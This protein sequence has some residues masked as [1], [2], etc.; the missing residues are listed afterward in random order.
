MTF[1]AFF[2]L[3]MYAVLTMKAFIVPTGSMGTT[4]LGYHKQITCP[5]CRASFQ[6]NASA[7]ADGFQ[8]VSGCTC[9]N[10]RFKIDFQQQKLS[11]WLRGG[12]RILATRFASGAVRRYDLAVHRHPPA[13]FEETPR[14]VHYVTR[15]LGLPGETLAVHYGRIYRSHGAKFQDG[16]IKPNEL[17]KRDFMHEDDASSLRLFN[18]GKFEIVRKSPELMMTLRRRV[19]DND[20][21]PAEQAAKRPPRWAA[22][23]GTSWK[24]DAAHGFRRSVSNK[25]DWLRYRHLLTADN[26]GTAARP[27][28]I[29]DFLSYNTAN[30]EPLPQ[31]WVGDLMLECEVTLTRPEGELWLELIKG[32]DR[33]QARWDLSTGQCRLWRQKPAW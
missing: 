9:F 7:E 10:C 18:Q 13:W 25:L 14:T 12:D 29:T 15:V 2:F 22:A 4:I 11:P 31:N 5:R 32:V 24:S 21:A 26:D 8:R 16:K 28:L 23:A 20:H 3:E 6:V 17:W 30:N 1:A 19:Y 33:F 27:Q